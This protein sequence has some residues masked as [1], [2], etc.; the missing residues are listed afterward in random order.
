[1][2]SEEFKRHPVNEKLPFSKLFIYGF[3]HVLA[4]YAGAVTVPLVIGGA[5]GLTSEQIIFLIN[6]DLFTCGIATLIQTIGFWKFGIRLPVIQGVTFAC[7]QPII[8]VGSGLLNEGFSSEQALVVIF[9]SVIVAGLFTLLIAPL[10][11]KLIRFFPPVVTGSVI[12][13]I[14]L[15][16]IPVGLKMVGGQSVVEKVVD[17]QAIFYAYGSKKFLLIAFIVIL[18]ILLCNRFLKGF[19]KNISILLG[20]VVGYVISIATGF[21]NFA[22]VGSSSWFGI[23]LPFGMNF[24]GFENGVYW[25]AVTHGGLLQAGLVSAI[26]SM[27]IV[28]IIVMV[29]STGDFIAIGEI[30]DLPIGEKEIAAGLRADG[31]STMLGGMFNAFPYTAFAQNVGLIAL[32]GVRSRWV[33]TA[34]GVILVVLGLV[35]KL[36]AL[37]ESIPKFVIGGA[38]IIMFAMVAANGIKTLTKAQLDTRPNN[39]FIIAMSIVAAIVPYGG[40]LLEK[41]PAGTMDVVVATGVNGGHFVNQFLFFGMF[42]SEMEPVLSSGI[43]LAAITAILLN[44]L[45]N[46]AGKKADKVK[47]DP[48]ND[49]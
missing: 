20:L 7:V 23:D 41:V 47:V 8:A 2:I 16:L 25:E 17:G 26:I 15:A 11:S 14:G 19:W 12:L 49:I 43:S 40:T 9:L 3:Q 32:T 38:A 13:S 33:V 42:P 4:M 44:L 1:M 24:P 45:F 29:E 27:I 34:S 36:G 37:V 5:L 39:L 22:K 35:P 31:L 6:A 48:V 10:F 46:G 30:I 21:V 28:M 18:V